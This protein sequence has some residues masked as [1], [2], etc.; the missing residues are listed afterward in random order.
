[1]KDYYKIL[2][3]DEDITQADLKKLYRQLSKKYHPDVNPEGEEK[4]KEIVEA[5]DVLGDEN[6]RKEYDYKRKNPF[7]QMGGGNGFNINDLFEQMMHGG[8]RQRA[9]APDKVVNIEVTC[10]ES[11]F[12]VKKELNF[13]SSVKCN[14]CDGTGGTRKVCETCNGNGFVIQVFGTGLFMQQIQQPCP[15]CKGTGS[16]IIR[17]CNTCLG[18]GITQQ[19][20]KF[21]VSIPPNVDNGDFLRVQGKGD[22]Y[23]KTKTYGDVILKINTLNI[24]GFEKVGADLVY[25]KKLT[26]L[27]LLVNDN[28]LIK[29]PE[30]D[31]NIKIP[32]T[33][34]TDKPLRIINKGYKTP[35]GTGNFYIKLTVEK[36]EDL[37]I[38]IKNKIKEL[39][40]GVNQ[41]FN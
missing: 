19:N 25:N 37:N 32:N 12:G 8:E 27:E 38:E 2:G 23:S 6:K 40:N 21:N 36:N 24:D 1:M 35:N 20:Q 15:N 17:A 29:H 28:M 14:P 30:G 4:F 13:I 3:V 26:P 18:N 33:L 7:S 10:I 41:T 5:Y 34:S 11:F 31:L 9:K 39:T 16:Q 22:Y